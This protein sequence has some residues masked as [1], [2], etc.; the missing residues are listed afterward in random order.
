M[1]QNFNINIKQE[2]ENLNLP[3][4]R[5]EKYQEALKNYLLTS[6]FPKKSF[7]NHVSSFVFSLKPYFRSYY[8]KLF[9]SNQQQ[10]MAA[11]HFDQ[12]GLEKFQTKKTN[13]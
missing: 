3:I 5:V 2:L 7:F 10:L 8:K 9:N 6:C 11:P 1:N 12:A 13:I 4:I